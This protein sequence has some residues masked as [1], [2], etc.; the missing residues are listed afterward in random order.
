MKRHLSYDSDDSENF[1]Q[2][3]SQQRFRELNAKLTDVLN[4]LNAVDGRITVQAKFLE[5]CY[6]WHDNINAK[7]IWGN[8]AQR[9]L[10]NRVSELMFALNQHYQTQNGKINAAQLQYDEM[11]ERVAGLRDDLKYMWKEFSNKIEINRPEYF[12]EEDFVS[13]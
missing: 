1:V 8:K 12:D 5:D 9:I 10:C 6:D 13:Y 7:I 2:K 3:T 11:I 4:T